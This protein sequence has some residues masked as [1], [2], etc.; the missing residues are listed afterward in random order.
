MEKITFKLDGNEYEADL[1]E[2]KSYKTMKQFAQSES[3]P[4]GM[5]EAMGRIFMGRDEEYIDGLGGGASDMGR[6]CD[7]A[8]E[9][10]KAKNSSGS[11]ATSKATA[12]K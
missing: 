7:A 12:K 4:A 8:F 10:A 2:L 9:A 11:P 3:D 6:L 1:D 5:F